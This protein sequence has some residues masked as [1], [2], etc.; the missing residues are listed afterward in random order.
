M[1]VLTAEEVTN[2]Y[3]YGTINTPSDLSND[4]HI[5]PSGAGPT[6]TTVNINDYMSSGPG[7]FASPAFFDVV[8]LFFSPTT[9][10]LP[11]GTYTEAQIRSMMGTS[12][13]IISQQQW[14]Y[15]DGAGDYEDRVY[16]WNTVAFEIDDNA[17]FVIA[18]DGTRRI[19][20]FAVIPF[21]NTN[22]E[23]FDFESDDWVATL[24]NDFLEETV[25]PSGPCG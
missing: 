1:T 24:G 18:A 5:R 2:L 21:S 11:P 7:R 8:K 15:D 17:S 19:E 3:L 9:S 20:N 16:V 23:N 25:D 6:Q 10:G 4:S 13:A 14:A 22:T 12:Q